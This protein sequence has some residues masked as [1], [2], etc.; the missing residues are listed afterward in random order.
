MTCG[1]APL[2]PFRFRSERLQSPSMQ[3]AASA[4]P[5]QAGRW[6]MDQ[7]EQAAENG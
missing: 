1:V 6:L 3:C 2:P 4:T 7:L 5:H